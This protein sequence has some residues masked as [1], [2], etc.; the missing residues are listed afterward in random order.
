M[1]VPSANNWNHYFESEE[2]SVIVVHVTTLKSATECKHLYK[3][4]TLRRSFQEEPIFDN[5]AA[6][7]R[8]K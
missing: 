5:N 4:S 7:L 1:Y 2:S 6:D 8:V 3:I